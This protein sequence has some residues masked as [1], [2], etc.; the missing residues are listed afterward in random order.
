MISK[1]ITANNKKEI[2]PTKKCFNTCYP[3]KK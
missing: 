3:E 2:S 1:F